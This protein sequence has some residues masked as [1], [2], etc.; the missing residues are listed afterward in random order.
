[1]GAGYPLLKDLI[2][3][4][5]KKKKSN[6]PSCLIQSAT[7][8]L[9]SFLLRLISLSISR[10]KYSHQIRIGRRDYYYLFEYYVVA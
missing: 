1:M 7:C 2:G 6:L 9:I 10:I 8:S 5:F 3:V 4:R